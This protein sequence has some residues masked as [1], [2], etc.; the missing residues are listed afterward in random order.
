M[1]R[2]Y[3]VSRCKGPGLVGSPHSLGPPALAHIDDLGRGTL[4]S[5]SGHASHRAPSLQGDSLLTLPEAP[6]ES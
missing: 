1:I 3:L 4:L 5:A 2:A 6:Q